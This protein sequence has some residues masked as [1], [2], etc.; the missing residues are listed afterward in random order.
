MSLDVYLTIPGHKANHL[1][2]GIFVREDGQTKEISRQ[3]WDAKFPGRE[4]IIYISNPAEEA[5]ATVYSA[6]ITHNLTGM[7]ASADLYHALWRPQELGITKAGE[8]IPCLEMGLERLLSDPERYKRYN[9]PNGWGSYEGLV[10]F[11]IK[12]L[13]ACREHPE[14][15]V[16]TWR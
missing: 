12:Y 4:P 14:A 7:A 15:D 11:V 8:L 16:G 2:S 3:E 9:P 5:D 10:G 6:N 1:G 13:A